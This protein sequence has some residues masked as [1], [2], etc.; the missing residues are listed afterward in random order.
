VLAHEVGLIDRHLVDQA[1]PFAARGLEAQQREVL[2]EIG[3]AGGLDAV[4]EAFVDEVAF[5][6]FEV[7][8][9]AA[10]K[11]FTEALEVFGADAA[12]GGFCRNVHYAPR[13]SRFSS[14]RPAKV[15]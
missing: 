7:D 11:I 3:A 1:L 12:G 2:A 6:R 14:R 15:M 10:V 5:G 13:P 8:A 9:A 4:D